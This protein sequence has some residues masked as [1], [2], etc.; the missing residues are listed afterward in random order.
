MKF[1]SL[2]RIIINEA[3]AIEDLGELSGDATSQGM[4]I[5]PTGTES[6]LETSPDLM[7]QD[8]K[9]DFLIKHSTVINNNKNLTRAEQEAKAEFIIQ[10]GFFDAIYDGVIQRKA[11][12]AGALEQLPAE[13][14]DPNA[15][16]DD[17]E[18]IK[19]A[20]ADHQRQRKLDA[21]ADEEFSGQEI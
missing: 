17:I 3:E 10:N 15:T 16:P 6:D 11:N 19:P 12:D 7:S 13:L 1:E 8:Q 4:G 2:Y 21:E 18:D 20:L 14:E 5:D 9:I